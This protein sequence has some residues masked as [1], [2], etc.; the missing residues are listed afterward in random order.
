M[1][2]RELY[3]QAFASLHA[4]GNIS[5]EA[6][7]ENR[8]KRKSENRVAIVCA[9]I[10]AA[11]MGCGIPCHAAYNLYHVKNLRVFLDEGITQEQIHEIG[12][13][14]KKMEELSNVVINATFIS[15]GEAWED[16]KSSYLTEELSAQFAENPL[17]D[18]ANYQV[19]VKI[20]TD[21]DNVREHIGQ[22]DGVR[23]VANLYEI[24]EKD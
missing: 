14:L 10:V 11:L 5:L 13:E 12:T 7:M 21:T 2:D 15:D 22:I 8:R 24:K 16:F 1:T 3:K 17:E 18:S 4:S 6:N 20:F 9:G 23:K 19:T